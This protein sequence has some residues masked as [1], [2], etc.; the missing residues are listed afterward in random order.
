MIKTS[1]IHSFFLLWTP[2]NVYHWAGTENIKGIKTQLFSLKSIA[3][4]M[5]CETTN[6]VRDITETVLSPARS[7]QSRIGSSICHRW[8]ELGVTWAG[9]Q[10]YDPVWEKEITHLCQN[11]LW[12]SS[13][14]VCGMLEGLRVLGKGMGSPGRPVSWTLSCWNPRRWLSSQ[15][16]WLTYTTPSPGHPCSSPFQAPQSFSAWVLEGDTL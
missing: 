3:G 9:R 16:S 6:T 2:V 7:K 10:G 12:N 1:F 5:T 14:E 11:R 8:R 15:R 13:G 4:D